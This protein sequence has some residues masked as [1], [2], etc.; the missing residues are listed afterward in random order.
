[1]DC[2]RGESMEPASLTSRVASVLNLRLPTDP[3]PN[4]TK[5]W[6]SKWSLVLLVREK[7]K[8]GCF[9]FNMTR[10]GLERRRRDEGR[11]WR[12]HDDMMM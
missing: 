8:F 5:P 7:S 9:L 12:S 6:V 11:A 1:M 10:C 4:L 3:N 2:I